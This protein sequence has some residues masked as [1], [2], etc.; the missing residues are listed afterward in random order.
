MSFRRGQRVACAA[1]EATIADTR[2]MLAQNRLAAFVP[3]K[4]QIVTIDGFGSSKLTGE[5]ML[6][7]VEEPEPG[8][9]YF[10]KYFRP[11]VED[12][13][14]ISTF[15][16]ILDAVNQRKFVPAPT[17]RLET[18][19]GGATPHPKANAQHSSDPQGEKGK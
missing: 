18:V 14:D 1:D 5:P 9:F 3:A 7:L 8:T 11:L 10:A 15:H 2:A 19:D 4:G 6:H 17:R 13:I 16:A 12:D